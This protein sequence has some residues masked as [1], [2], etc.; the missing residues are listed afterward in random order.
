V[1]DQ[2]EAELGLRGQRIAGARG[3]S[4]P[5]TLRYSRAIDVAIWTYLR[6]GLVRSTLPSASYCWCLAKNGRVRDPPAISPCPARGVPIECRSQR[7][8]RCTGKLVIESETR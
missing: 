2:L 1:L 6:P 4:L 7:S 3:I 8:T 5:Q